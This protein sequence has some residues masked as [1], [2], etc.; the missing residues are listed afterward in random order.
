MSTT[1][2]AIEV[3]DLCKTY[4]SV[5]SV[6]RISFDVH[7]GEVFGLLGPNGAGKTTTVEML[8]GYRTPTSGSACVLGQDPQQGDRSWRERI[9]LVLQ[10]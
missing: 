5:E 1:D 8:E 10:E 9:G 7:V 3:H 2:L 6:R 4:G